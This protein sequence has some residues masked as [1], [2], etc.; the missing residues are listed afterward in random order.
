M[1]VCQLTEL[2]QTGS[3]KGTHTDS[4]ASVRHSCQKTW[5]SAVE[6]GQ[7]AKR[8]EIKLEMKIVQLD[9]GGGSSHPCPLLD[10]LKR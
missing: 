2:K 4:G 6:N 10:Y 7:E 8:S 9:N 1:Q 5:E 3:R